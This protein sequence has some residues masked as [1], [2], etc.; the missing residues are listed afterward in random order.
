MKKP[1]VFLVLVVL[2]IA[3]QANA[4]NYNSSTIQGGP[5][6]LSAGSAVTNND[7]TINGQT[8]VFCHTPH[9]GKNDKPLWNRNAP[10]STYSLYTSTTTV[11]T[12]TSG[13]LQGSISGACL[14]CHDGTIGLDVMINANGGTLTSP[15]AFAV[16]SGAKNTY[17]NNLM[18]GT[19]TA[20]MGTDLRND[21]PININYLTAYNAFNPK[22][23]NAVV[24]DA[25]GVKVTVGSLPLYTSQATPTVEC[26]TC[27]DPHNNTLGNFLRVSNQGSAMCKT[28]HIK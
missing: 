25:N 22:Q 15:V 10:T 7:A 14:S 21:H 26:A 8:C 20:L 23:H 2:A 1:L 11:A 9:G 18:G 3:A 5:H 28:C 24:N 27:H 17:A 19:G 6:D 16:R 13:G 12:T 4:Q